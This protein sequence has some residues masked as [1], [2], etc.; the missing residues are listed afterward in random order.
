VGIIIIQR[1]FQGAVTQYLI[2]GRCT[3]NGKCTKMLLKQSV[4]AYSRLNIKVFNTV[5]KLFK[6]AELRVLNGKLF[7]AAGPA[8][9]N[10]F[11]PNF[12]LVLEF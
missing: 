10:A 1:R 7:Q 12:V 3:K 4:G 9:A 6:V 5:L 2:Q 8:T 11:S